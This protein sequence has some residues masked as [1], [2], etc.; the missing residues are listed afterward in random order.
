MVGGGL[1]HLPWEGVRTVHG[2]TVY[3]HC[4]FPELEVKKCY[5]QGVVMKHPGINSLAMNCPSAPLDTQYLTTTGS[6]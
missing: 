3:S 6:V 5:E 1:R 4:C 2:W